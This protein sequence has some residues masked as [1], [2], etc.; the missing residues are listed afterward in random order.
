MPYE[1][2]NFTLFGTMLLSMIAIAWVILDILCKI[3]D[4]FLDWLFEKV[5]RVYKYSIKMIKFLMHAAL[6]VGVV[7]IVFTGILSFLFPSSFYIDLD[8]NNHNFEL[9]VP[10]ATVSGT[11]VD[12]NTGYLIKPSYRGLNPFPSGFPIKK[13]DKI[14]MNLFF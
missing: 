8:S 10:L 1:I 9:G 6:T 7:F 11:Y 14:Y 4:W 12:T 2:S 3:L 5:V 13:L